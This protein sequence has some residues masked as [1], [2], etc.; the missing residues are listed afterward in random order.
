METAES[1]SSSNIARANSGLNVALLACLA[2]AVCY[3]AAKLGGFLIIRDPQTLWPLWPGCAALVAILLVIPRES[4]ALVMAAGLAGFAVYDL[5]AGVPIRAM[6]WLILADILEILVAAWGVNYA[7]G[8]LPRLNSLK[9]L[10]K[11]SFFTVFLASVIV[12]TIGVYGLDGNWWISWRISFL[13]E[14]LAFLTVAPAILGGVGEGSRWLRAPR[15]QVLEA[16][17]LI[18]A[19][20]SLSYVMFVARG[21]SYPPALLYSLLPLLLWSALR[22]GTT[23]V[24]AAATIVALLSIW[25]ALH[26]RGPFIEQ[27]PIDRV[28]SLQLFLW[29]AVIPFMIL[30]AQVEERRQA[31]RELREGE[32]RLRLAV[33]AGRMY[34][35]EWDAA[36]DEIVRSGEYAAV[37]HWKCDARYD[38]GREFREDI[39]PEDL[40]KYTEMKKGLSPEKSTYKIVYRVRRPGNGVVW[41]EENG[42]AFFNAQ[43]RV[44]RTIGI[45]SDI[46]ERKKGEEALSS[47]SQKLI[48]AQEQERTRIARELHDD[49]S[50]RMALLGIGLTQFE[51][52]I[53]ELPSEA[54]ERLHNISEVASEVSSELHSMSHQLHPAKLDLLG[55]VATVGAHCREISQQHELRIEF[56]HHDV[57]DR[58]P[59]DVA[60]CLFRIVQEALRNIVKHGRTESATVELS[61][62]ADEIY[63]RI[64]DQGAGFCPESA[65][66]RGGLGLISMRERLRLIGGDLDVESEPSRGTRIYVRVPVGNGGAQEKNGAKAFK[67]NV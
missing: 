60:L 57:S 53:P 18:T 55:L 19:L 54:Q 45:V 23:G 39:F 4:W 1:Q 26:G 33:E 37:L 65:Q 27:D 11:Y 8:G 64:S 48:E 42:R 24:G 36:T 50:Q 17:V 10:A 15:A 61:G 59:K 9:A 35:F 66:A 63:L 47:V 43:G 7:L 49:L 58:I 34:A 6:A 3:L 14:G 2:A 22:F 41:M 29:F 20:I 28:L 30:A 32:E 44:L 51:R 13:S 16:C 40:W 21:G 46:T 25:G 67:A 5:Q 56:V 62:S 52:S 12:S 38:T 31:E